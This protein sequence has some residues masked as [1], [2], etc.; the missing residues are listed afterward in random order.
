[1]HHFLWLVVRFR[2]ALVIYLAAWML[3]M[4]STWLDPAWMPFD[5]LAFPLHWGLVAVGS[6]VLRDAIWQDPGHG[7]DSFWRT[8]PPR[9]KSLLASQWMFLIFCIAGPAI[10]V[11]WIN[12]LL[13]DNSARNWTEGV[14]DMVGVVA[15]LALAGAGASFSKSWR[16]MLLVFFVG[17]GSH[18]CGVFW[19]WKWNSPR[20]MNFGS[21]NSSFMFQLMIYWFLPAVLGAV[22]WACGL[23]YGKTWLRAILAC[24]VLF[25]MP[26]ITS[27]LWLEGT[28]TPR[29][30]QTITVAAYS[31]SLRSDEQRFGDLVLR[32][33]NPGQHVANLESH[34]NLGH[35]NPNS[36][37]NSRTVLGFDSGRRTDLDFAIRDYLGEGEL[38]ALFPPETRWY[39][40]FSGLPGKPSWNLD[41][42]QKLDS[43]FQLDGHVTGVLTSMKRLAEMPLVEGASACGNGV[44]IHTEG[45]MVTEDE[46]SFDATLWMPAS[47]LR[48]TTFASQ[49]NGMANEGRILY[50]LQFPAIP[51]A[52]LCHNVDRDSRLM[53][54]QTM[55][56]HLRISIT[57]PTAERIRRIRFTPETMRDARLVVCGIQEEGRFKA[58]ADPAPLMPRR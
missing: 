36:T 15:L 18:L 11:W 8:R 19:L 29:T 6:F 42:P 26:S 44:R 27:L 10:L 43:W 30:D 7:T 16:G 2:L 52:A 23:K 53:S 38:R 21:G 54:W 45:L 4:T 3:L 1:M 22:V 46:I 17:L 50:V 35:I 9:W 12:G 49:T 24:L 14:W 33:L 48:P 28:M 41:I 34:L 37:V 55:R 13:L 56:A 47:L 5:R 57:V 20:W 32:G 51:M 40:G 58:M 25:I 31:G 39:S